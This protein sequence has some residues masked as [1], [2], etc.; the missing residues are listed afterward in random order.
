VKGQKRGVKRNSGETRQERW[1][2]A[3]DARQVVRG[4]DARSYACRR[5]ACQKRV[6][7]VSRTCWEC[8]SRR[9]WVKRAG[10]LGDG[11]RARTRKGEQEL[12]SDCWVERSFQ[13][14]SRADMTKNDGA[15]G[16]N[17]CAR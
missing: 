17:W 15:E 5:R 12:T 11:L 3:T 10:A 8:V 14:S 7:D 6:R 9:M 13:Q 2:K 1:N 16:K 4:P